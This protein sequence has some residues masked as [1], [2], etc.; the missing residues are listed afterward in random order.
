M[1]VSLSVVTPTALC[2]GSW[3]SHQTQYMFPELMSNALRAVQPEGQIP[4]AGSNPMQVRPG[5]FPV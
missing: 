2:P 3:Y 1:P 4:L 5:E